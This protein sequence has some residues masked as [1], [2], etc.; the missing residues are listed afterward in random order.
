G[1]YK[2]KAARCL[3][4]LKVESA[5][6]DAGMRLRV[7]HDVQDVVVCLGTGG[8]DGRL[9]RVPR[10]Q[11][12]PHVIDEAAQSQTHPNE[13]LSRFAAGQQHD[14]RPRNG[15]GPA[16]RVGPALP[17]NRRQSPTDRFGTEPLGLAKHGNNSLRRNDL[18]VQLPVITWYLPRPDSSYSPG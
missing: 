13:R 11:N 17:R 15:D 8:C 12:L 14:K 1:D 9:R 18:D 3:T 10:D 7:V 2:P 6:R 4:G 16:S 5:R